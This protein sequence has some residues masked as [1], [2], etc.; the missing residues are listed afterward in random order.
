MYVMLNV[1]GV[2]GSFESVGQKAKAVQ[3]W[4]CSV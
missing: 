1:Q 3:G 4:G 2:L